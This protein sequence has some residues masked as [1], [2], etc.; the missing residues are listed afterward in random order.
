M[1]SLA[2]LFTTSVAVPVTPRGQW[3][4]KSAITWLL[5]T[6]S[7]WSR[8]CA[9]ENCCLSLNNLGEKR[10]FLLSFHQGVFYELPSLLWN[11][12][13]YFLKQCWVGNRKLLLECKGKRE[14]SRL[15]FPFCNFVLWT[16]KWEVSE[17]GFY[18]LRA[19][20]FL[21]MLPRLHQSNPS[22]MITPRACD[23]AALIL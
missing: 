4:T 11:A 14:L 20:K 18:S 16:L 3:L 8:H 21:L 22:I 2:R 10:C 5:K 7:A 12:V 13:S 9:A 1:M 23:P 6:V 17:M 15:V 19:H